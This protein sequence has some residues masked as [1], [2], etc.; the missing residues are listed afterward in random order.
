M[1]KSKLRVRSRAARLRVRSRAARLRLRSRAATLGA[2][3]TLAASACLF[4]S[5]CSLGDGTGEVRSDNLIAKDCWQGEYDLQPD[6]FAA[7]PFRDSL[8]IRVQ[9]GSDLEGVSDGIM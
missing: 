6:F 7:E 3:V 2:L 4:G 8:Y 5:A 1:K 9:R